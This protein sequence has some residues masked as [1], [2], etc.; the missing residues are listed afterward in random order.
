MVSVEVN[1]QQGWLHQ[2]GTV[3]LLARSIDQSTTLGAT[4]GGQAQQEPWK[5]SNITP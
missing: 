5:R 3:P 4:R 2:A 1:N